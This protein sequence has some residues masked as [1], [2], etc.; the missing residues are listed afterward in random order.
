MAS[1][2]HLNPVARDY[3]FK[4]PRGV[5][6]GTDESTVLAFHQSLPSYNET[7][8]HTLPSLAASLGLSHVLVKDESDRFG[9]PAFK[10]LGASWAV[11]RA[12][13]SALEANEEQNVTTA[14]TMSVA[15]LGSA[16]R[17]RGLRIVTSTEGNCGRAVARMAK[18]LGLPVRVSV[19]GYMNE[20]TRQKI[21]SEGAEVLVVKGSYEDTIPVIRK[22]AEE[23]EGSVLVLDVGLEGYEVVPKYFVEGY[24]S[25][26]AESEKQVPEL[27]GG[28][29]ATHAIV[30]CGAGSIAQAVVQHYKGAERQKQ[31][32]SATVI[33]VE[34]T[35][36]ACLKA[37]LEAGESTDVTTTD[38][39][40]N[41]MNCGTL[42]TLAWPVLSEG[43]DASVVVTDQESH[44]AV[45]ELKSS[46][47]MA[48]PCGAATLAALRRVCVDSRARSELALGPESIVVL[49]CTEGTRD[50]PVPS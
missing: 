20:G 41:G 40:M 50:Y 46:G 21:R 32:G 33:A 8:L 36:A 11:Y 23:R 5:E 48:G 17:D 45:E 2:I 14:A 39:I 18:Y 1:F 34:A 37:S 27:T 30:P 22:D 47:T 6:R 42:S 7:T 16:A 4:A 19:P 38:T 29:P 25:M 9:L 24:S 49:H 12:V 13:L 3:T 26:L 35:T 31:H 43:V 15:D 10:I 28:K 44:S